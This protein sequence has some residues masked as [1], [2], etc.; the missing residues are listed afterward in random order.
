MKIFNS[1]H[2]H[3]DEEVRFVA[4][5]SGYFDMRSKGDKWIRLELSVGDFLIIPAG[6]YH[7]FYLDHKVNMI[8]RIYE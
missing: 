6:A 2:L 4:E 8:E 7:R 5:G 3:P 1:E